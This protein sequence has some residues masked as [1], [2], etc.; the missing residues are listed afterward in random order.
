MYPM[1]IMGCI[2]KKKKKKQLRKIFVLVSSTSGVISG[3]GLKNLVATTAP[4]HL[5]WPPHKWRFS[6]SSAHTEKLCLTC[7]QKPCST[8]D[9]NDMSK[10]HTGGF[11][12]QIQLRAVSAHSWGLSPL[13]PQPVPT[14]CWFLHHVLCKY[15]SCKGNY[16]SGSSSFPETIVKFACE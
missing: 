16:G 10:Y 14:S 15:L 7:T 6:T 1:K 3:S 2:V 5:S 12:M 8:W 9:L 13:L 4:Q 11:A